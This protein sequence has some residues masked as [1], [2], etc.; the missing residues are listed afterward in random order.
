[1]T[2]QRSA[3]YL[4]MLN[5]KYR[6]NPLT[7]KRLFSCEQLCR[8][9]TFGGTGARVFINYQ[10]RVQI[11]SFD[12]MKSI[13]CKFQTVNAYSSQEN[14]N[15]FL[16][17]WLLDVAIWFFLELESKC[18]YQPRKSKIAS[19]IVYPV[20]VTLPLHCECLSFSAVSSDR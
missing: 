20:I 17:A 1:M 5:I 14:L 16:W 11:L 19:I 18:L 7:S 13:A 10:N 8:A 3:V 15:Y 6:N 9:Q 2:E 12:Y 4:N